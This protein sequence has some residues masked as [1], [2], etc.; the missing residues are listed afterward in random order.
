M[1]R[2][3]SSSQAPALF[4][5]P[6]AH[7][8]GLRSP[9][10]PPLPSGPP[11]PKSRG[12]ALRDWAGAPILLLVHPPTATNDHHA[13]KPFLGAPRCLLKESTPKSS[14]VVDPPTP[15][16]PPWATLSSPWS[17]APNTVPLI[18]SNVL[19]PPSLYKGW[20]YNKDG[21]NLGKAK[22]AQPQPPAPPHCPH[23]NPSASPAPT[24]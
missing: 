8:C 24:P 23:A 14:L 4:F 12:S 18:C 10:H 5:R 21:G 16:L 3:G 13:S 19:L 2:W 1:R 20:G 9:S 7:D 17:S 15:H 22:D 11:G 6:R